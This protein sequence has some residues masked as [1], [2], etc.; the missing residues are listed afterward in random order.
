MARGYR[1]GNGCL[2]AASQRLCWA[3]VAVMA[4]LGPARAEVHGA[5]RHGVAQL[6]VVGQATAI[7]LELSSPGVNLLGFEHRPRTEL[8][9]ARLESV[10][11]LL[12]DGNHL[13][14][15]RHGRCHLLDHRLD[16][17]AIAS[18]QPSVEADSGPGPRG[19]GRH[20][21]ITATYRFHCRLGEGV[22]ELDTEVL[23]VFPGIERLDVQWLIDGRQ[24]A[25]SLDKRRRYIRFK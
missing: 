23:R 10:R 6:R 12:A 22:V 24:G 1:H 13:F 4:M 2:A 16:V 7:N 8:Q 3:L 5:H 25:A 20:P 11:A 18:P 21:N 9:R 17:G 19:A 14:S 15:L